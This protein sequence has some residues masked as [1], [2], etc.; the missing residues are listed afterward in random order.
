MLDKLVRPAQVHQSIPLTHRAQ[1][2][3]Y[4][5][6]PSSGPHKLREAL[7]LTVL[8]KNRLRY[9]LSGREVTMIVNQRLVKV[10]GKVR[11]DETYPAGFQDVVTLDKSGELC[12]GARVGGRTS[13]TTRLQLPHPVRRQGPLRR[14]P[15]LA[16]GGQL[17]A[18]QGQARSARRQGRAFRRVRLIAKVHRCS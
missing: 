9:A 3:T 14:P 6:R 7:P 18:V 2:G 8:L 12:A 16:G 4:A 1:G 13:L 10:D 11:T 17:Q 15:H 5:P